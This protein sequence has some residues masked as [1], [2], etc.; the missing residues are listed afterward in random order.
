MRFIILPI[1]VGVRFGTQPAAP[2]AVE[3][4]LCFQSLPPRIMAISGAA[5]LDRGEVVLTMMSTPRHAE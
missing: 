4:A 5:F 1:I 3:G 2:G